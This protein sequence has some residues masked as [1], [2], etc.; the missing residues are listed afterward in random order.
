MVQVLQIPPSTKIL[1]HAQGTCTNYMYYAQN[2]QH[3]PEAVPYHKMLQIFLAF[4]QFYLVISSCILCFC[5][6]MKLWCGNKY[7]YLSIYHEQFFDIP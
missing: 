2:I 7:I 4:S 1:K 5:I 6:E 3:G